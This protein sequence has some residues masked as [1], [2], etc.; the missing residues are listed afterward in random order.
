MTHERSLTQACAAEF[1]GC[2]PSSL[3]LDAREPDH[4]CP[5]FGV[6]DDEFSKVT[7][8]HRR[9]RIADLRKARFHCRIT[10][11]STDFLVEYLD[12]LD[13]RILRRTDTLPAGC[14]IPRQN[15]SDCGNTR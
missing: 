5:F 8:R 2:H 9:G 12:Y 10:K 14:L 6:L 15:F 3:R 1:I 7:D 13:G 4:L 11:G